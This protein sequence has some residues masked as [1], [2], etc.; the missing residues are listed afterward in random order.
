MQQ[1]AMGFQK[2]LLAAQTL[3]L[4]PAT[5]VGI[6]MGSQ[7]APSH[8]AIIDAARLGTELPRGVHVAWPSLRGGK[9]RGRKRE[10]LGRCR[11]LLTDGTR[12]FV[13]E[14]RKR[15]GVSGVPGKRRSE[16]AGGRAGCDS[17]VCPPFI[18]ET[19]QPQEDYQQEVVEQEGVYHSVALLLGKIDDRPPDS[20]AGD[21]SARWRYTT[22]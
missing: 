4:P 16:L 12:G 6:A 18:L 14:A 3:E 21:L 10:G 13:G 2:V 9:Q 22:P 1:R 20:Q 19:T 7:I 8:P 15:R 11:H 17:G 5:A